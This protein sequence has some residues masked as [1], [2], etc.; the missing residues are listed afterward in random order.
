ME[1]T[2][3]GGVSSIVGTAGNVGSVVG[4]F[5]WGLGG[6]PGIVLLGFLQVGCVFWFVCGNHKRESIP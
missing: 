5:V 6:R 4:T 2:A 1:P 3:C